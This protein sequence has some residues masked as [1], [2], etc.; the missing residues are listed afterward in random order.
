MAI[1]YTDN[2]YNFNISCPRLDPSLLP[3]SKDVHPDMAGEY[4]TIYLY[5]VYNVIQILIV[6]LTKNI[7]CLTESPEFII[8]IH[9]LLHLVYKYAYHNNVNCLKKIFSS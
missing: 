4:S 8:I 2:V 9:I 7:Y 5:L 6:Q 3:E 1:V